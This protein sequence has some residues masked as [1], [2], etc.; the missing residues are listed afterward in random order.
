MLKKEFKW[1][2]DKSENNAFN[3]I[4]EAICAEKVLK[5]YNQN[6]ELFLQTDAS[7]VGVGAIILQYNEKGF[8]QP[9]AYASRVLNT[10]ERN[11]PQIERELLGIVFGVTKFRLFVL[12]RKFILQTDHKPI[13]KIC[14]EHENV[15]QLASN[16]IKK[17]SML[18]KAYDFQIKHIPGKDNVVADFLY[19][20]TNRTTARIH[21]FIYPG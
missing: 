13:T 18:L 7:G 14:N 12:G 3:K 21:N 6:A 17:W 16:R 10:A 4:K 15:T 20:L 11:Y 5:R 8:L 2:W 1:K 9:I 19:H